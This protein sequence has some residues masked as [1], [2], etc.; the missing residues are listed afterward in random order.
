MVGL[1]A[2]VVG[3]LQIT[4]PTRSKGQPYRVSLQN[5]WLQKAGHDL[6]TVTIVTGFARGTSL[7]KRCF[8]LVKVTFLSRHCQWAQ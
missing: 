4:N 1:G 3:P 5:V 7:G 6:V 2:L 8:E